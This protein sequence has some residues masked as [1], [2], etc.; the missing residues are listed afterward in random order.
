MEELQVKRT[1][2]LI[3]AEIN[4]IKDDTRRVVIYNCIEIGRRLCEAKELIPH[5]E[6]E[7]WLESEV[8]YSKSTAKNLMKIFT[9]YGANQINLLGDNLKSQT[10]GDLSYS[11]AVLL[12]GI[13]EEAREKFVKENDVEDMSSRELKKAIDDLKK[14]KV[15]IKNLVKEKQDAEKRAKEAEETRKVL[16]ESFN[17][18]AEDRKL[19]EQE[20]EAILNQKT[21]LEIKIK[22]L[23]QEILDAKNIPNEIAISSTEVDEEVQAEINA[24][25]EEKER[26]AAEKDKLEQQLKNINENKSDGEVRYKVHFNNIVSDFQKLLEELA[27]MKNDNEVQYIKY[28]NATKKFIQTML[29]RL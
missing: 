5:G 6:W 23:E 15:D 17:K 21:S 3:A 26:L 7:K 8:S 4:K 25:K 19:L 11:Q 16:E 14:A 12:L 13:P 29:N 18:G 20:K 27:N 22:T 1:P 10:F 24:L 28:N 2:I 9:E